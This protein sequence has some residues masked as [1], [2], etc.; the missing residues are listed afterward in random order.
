MRPT[1]APAFAVALALAASGC[2]VKNPDFCC[3]SL[4]SCRQAGLGGL[5]V[6]SDPSQPFC[7]DDG[8]YGVARSCI[9]DPGTNACTGPADCATPDQP[10]CD[11]G[12]AGTC[13]GCAVAADCTRFA[14]TPQCDDGTGVCV[15]CRTSADCG[16]ASP[17][18]G[19]D[20]TCRSCAAAAECAAGL[21]T[22][23]GTCPPAEQV[24]YVD[25]TA[26]AGNVACTAGAPCRTITAGVAAATAARRYL[27][28]APGM[29]A[30]QVILDGRAIEVSATGA[31]L[32]SSSNPVI[33][34]RNGATLTAS[35]LRIRGGVG[36]GL[37]CT[38]ST[39]VL[40]GVGIEDNNGVGVEG[41]G[42]NLT[43]E[44]ARVLGNR[45]GGLY[46]SGGRIAIRNA[47]IGKNGSL[48]SV[49]GG[50]FILSP[51]DLALEFTTIADNLVSSGAAGLFCQTATVVTVA[52][53][54]V[55]GAAGN[56][57]QADTCAPRYTLSNQALAGATNLVATP[58]FR[59]AAAGDY[60]LV[61]GS[62][63]IDQADPAATFTIDID[64]EARPAGAHADVGADEVH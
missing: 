63:G 37:R 52:N 46:L 1:L 48:S 22:Q 30:E 60:H 18:C 45:A 12:G 7:D 59:N 41:S 23:A 14:A 9:A 53:D 5:V 62:P 57:V 29:Y 43:L 31:E 42:C 16:G 35:G 25:S 40:R 32:G 2:S 58:T 49:V 34:V 61:A 27:E 10:V 24:I 26:A 56:Q 36:R 4:D 33:E 21:C 20:H 64:G 54:I 55:V 28:I 13:V 39:A 8:V 50:A 44:Q 6:C 19:T 17:V 47:F 38:D 15:A 51:F 3:S 11:V